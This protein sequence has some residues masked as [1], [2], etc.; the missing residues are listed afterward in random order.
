MKA[1]TYLIVNKKTKQWYYGIRYAAGCRYSDI[2]TTYFSSSSQLQRDIEIMGVDNFQCCIRKSFDSVEDGLKWESKV[3]RRM[4]VCTN[5]ASYNKHHQM[6]FTVKYGSDN[7]SKTPEVRKKLSDAAFRRSKPT[8][9]TIDKSSFT[10]ISNNIVRIIKTPKIQKSYRKA[11]Q[12]YILWIKAYKPRC[13]HI[14]SV[15]ENAIISIDDLIVDKKPRV[16]PQLTPMQL[17][18][19]GKKISQ[20]LS[21]MLYYTNPDG[22]VTKR[23]KDSSNVPVGWVRGI[24]A[25]DIEKIRLSSTGRCHSDITKAK[26]REIC[27]GKAYYTSPD[28]LHV[29]AFRDTSL[30]PDGW[31]RGNKVKSRNDKISLYLKTVRHK[32][33]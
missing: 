8:Q 6:G 25:I 20:S 5:D 1:F 17:E 21:C 2:L 11:Y 30:V 7:K 31:I 24:K 26:M 18:D 13:L 19:R 14:L 9:A 4:K 32:C 23:F 3:L 33:E 28:L 16:A 10:R 27:K 29:R 12:K 15:L 22:T